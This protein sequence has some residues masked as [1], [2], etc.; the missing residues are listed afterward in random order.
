MDPYAVFT[1]GSQKFVSKTIYSGGMNPK[2]DD[3]IMTFKYDD[4][5]PMTKI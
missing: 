4:S 2:W 5:N 1:Y 3:E